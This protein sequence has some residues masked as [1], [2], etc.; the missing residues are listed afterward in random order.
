MAL[1]NTED[2]YGSV[3]RLFHWVLFLMILGAVIGGLY[4]SS[5]PDGPE[6]YELV[7]MHKAFGFIIL[8]LALARLFWRLINPTPKAVVGVSERN[9][10][11]ASLGHWALYV[12]MIV[13]PLS[14]MLMSQSAGYPVSVFGLFDVP[15][16][17]AESEA[18]AKLLHN[19]HGTVWGV[20]SA[21][22]LG[23]TGM[24]FWHHYRNQDSTLVRMLKG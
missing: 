23:H 2:S 21:L 17:V 20:L 3:A 14:G 10:K 11:L 24:A 16:L 7:M 8:C 6:K 5:L 19:I 13:Q 1:R 12:L 15:T 22:V 9:Q 18:N 4:E